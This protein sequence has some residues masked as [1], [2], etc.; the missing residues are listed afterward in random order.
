MV[1][2]GVT[3]GG[4]FGGAPD[5][6]KIPAP[7]VDDATTENAANAERMRRMRALG[8]QQSIFAGESAGRYAGGG[9]MPTLSK[10]GGS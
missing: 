2:G 8:K 4:L 3:M 1:G 5:T 6:P 10:L 9:S 7:K